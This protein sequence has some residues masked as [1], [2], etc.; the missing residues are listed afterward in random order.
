[1]KKKSE[2]QPSMI[3]MSISAK[4]NKNRGIRVLVKYV[5]MCMDDIGLK[6]KKNH[7]EGSWFLAKSLFVRKVENC[8]W[9]CLKL[10]LQ[11]EN[12][13]IWSQFL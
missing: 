11:L 9:C 2:K 6:E 8:W 1:M 3:I 4:V 5:M 13:K 12:D 10:N 7:E